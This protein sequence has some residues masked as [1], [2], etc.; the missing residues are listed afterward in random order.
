MK[1]MGNTRKVG[2]T[3]K[4]KYLIGAAII[5]C[6]VVVGVMIFNIQNNK[7][8]RTYS[9]Q[10]NH[11]QALRNNLFELTPESMGITINDH[12]QAFGA[13]M[14]ISYPNGVATLVAFL[15]GETSLLLSS[16]SVLTGGPENEK[17]RRAALEFVKS[18]QELMPVMEKVE[19]HLLPQKGFIRFYILTEI[20][21]FSCEEEQKKI[22][23][24]RL[25]PFFSNG[26][27]VISELRQ[28]KK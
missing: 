3:M 10:K 28:I 19:S 12:Q 15:N 9:V 6:L 11:Y 16:G 1:N 2:K 8:N 22:T 4:L 17:I 24:S 27:K 7:E 25:A 18:G 26:Q 13:I 21:A 5:I 14:E 23:N 20:G